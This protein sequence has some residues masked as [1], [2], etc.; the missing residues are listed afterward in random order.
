[1]TNELPKKGDVI[2]VRRKGRGFRPVRAVV[3]TGVGRDSFLGCYVNNTVI[4]TQF[5][6]TEF[7]W[8]LPKEV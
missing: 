3:V 8:E 4:E 2:E 7:E 1:M 5:K 6:P